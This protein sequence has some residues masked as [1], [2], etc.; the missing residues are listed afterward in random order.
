MPTSL[1]MRLPKS[2]SPEEFESLCKDVL[3]KEYNILSFYLTIINFF[4]SSHT[5]I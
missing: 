3:I 5:M 1:L 4:P 2:E